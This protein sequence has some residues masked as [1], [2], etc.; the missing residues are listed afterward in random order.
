MQYSTVYVT[1]VDKGMLLTHGAHCHGDGH[2]D[3]RV[4]ESIVS[5]P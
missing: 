1:L 5:K 4:R 3:D 2:R